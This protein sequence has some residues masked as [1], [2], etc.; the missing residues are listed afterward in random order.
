[1]TAL[2]IAIIGVGAPFWG[3]KQIILPAGCETV[4]DLDSPCA[5][6]LAK[7]AAG[8]AH[9]AESGMTTGLLVSMTVDIPFLPSDFV[10]RMIAGM[11]DAPGAYA[12]W[13]KDFYPPNTSWRLDAL[14]KLPSVPAGPHASA[15]LKALQRSLEAQ[16]VDWAAGS[17]ANPFAN[18]NTL[19]DLMALQCRATS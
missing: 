6:L 19:D 13:G 12:A 8:V 3:A 4:P 15:S 5:G 17:R 2:G 16:R 10:T 1:M 7:L 18:I 14:Q 11:D 9:L